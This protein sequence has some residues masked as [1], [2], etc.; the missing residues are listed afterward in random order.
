MENYNPVQV[1]SLVIGVF[2]LKKNL[3]EMS[4]S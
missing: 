3:L 2:E 1:D 4:C